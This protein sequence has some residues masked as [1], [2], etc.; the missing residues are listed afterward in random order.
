MKTSL[1]TLMAAGVAMLQI[2]LCATD[3]SRASFFE[4]KIRPT[5][6]KHCYE[7]HSVDS[8]TVKGGL[9]LDSREGLLEGGD[10]GAAVVPGEIGK[11][12]L[13]AALRYEDGLEMPPTGALPEDIVR[14]FE[15]WIAAGAY[16]PREADPASTSGNPAKD[17]MTLD[18][19]TLW[20]LRP[21][22]D[23]AEPPVKN[24]DWL[25]SPVDAFI[26]SALEAQGMTPAPDVDWYQLCR[27][28]H[29]DLIGLP[30]STESL[31]RFVAAATENGELALSNLVDRLLASDRF[32]ERW[33]RHW[34]DVARFA[35]SNGKS[36]DV[37]FPHAWR[38]RR[39]V[40]DAFNND[41]PHDQ[42]IREQIAGDLMKA[43][44]EAESN[45]QRIATGFLA[46]GSKSL[47]GGNL[48][49][50]LIDDQI[51]VVTRGFLGLTVS[52]ARC[53]D[54]KFD[55]IPTADYYALGGIFNNTKTYYGGGPKRPQ[56]AIE[57]ADVWMVLNDRDGVKTAELR[58]MKT[59]RARLEKAVKA[60][61]AE[62]KKLE[63]SQ[64]DE[65]ETLQ[66]LKRKRKETELS[67]KRIGDR[68]EEF[69]GDFAMGVGD[70]GRKGDLEIRI[71]GE[72]NQR[73][74]KVTRGFLT[75]L[76]MPDVPAIP[77]DSSGRQELSDWLN[78]PSNP[79]TL[80]VA[81][82]RVWQHLFGEGLVRTVDNFGQKG[83][84]PS[85]PE[86]LDYLA[87]RFREKGRTHKALIRDLVLSRV[88]RV[89]HEFDANA[90]DLDPENRLLWRS[91]RRRL[92]VESV[93]DALLSSSG[94]LELTPPEKSP[95][96]EIGEGEVGRGINEKPLKAKFYHRAVYLP[97]LR[98]AMIDIHK[99]FDFPDPSNLQGRRDVTNVPSQALFMMN[100]DLV[101]EA[102]RALAARL[103]TVTSAPSEE[104]VREAFMVIYGRP[105]SEAEGSEAIRFMKRVTDAGASLEGEEALALFCQALYA[106]A[107]FRYL[108]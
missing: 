50:D 36:R 24:R 65:A 39:W 18:T 1:L 77:V 43:S 15:Q 99:T 30:P 93:R 94:L 88:Y 82:N 98:T 96:A 52:C 90:F 16:D 33:G 38:Y 89:S 79:L 37:L 95:V 74:K 67:L 92:E 59:E 97:V 31:A 10:T 69:D 63:R 64:P 105:P 106:S 47:S 75:A 104:S 11:S 91:H 5:L 35:E 12:R 41:L 72:K 17:K 29:F 55:P 85:H 78:S 71:R 81:V 51:D 62:L 19:G 100:S 107:E 42:F 48:P 87:N 9:R 7:C 86:L 108:P 56:G 60:I 61:Q 58:R 27:R 21:I 44:T 102:A 83:E 32:G 25:R 28:V 101:S 40:I 14:H 103:R 70:K 68:E 76:E 53:H 46:M 54:H 3:E 73:G 23:V 6:I 57:A 8:K 2:S 45:R 49:L 4:K 66:R 80:R 13:I 22:Q 26:L 20:S 34:L 84:S